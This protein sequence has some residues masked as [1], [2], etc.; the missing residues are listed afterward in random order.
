MQEGQEPLPH[1]AMRVWLAVWEINR[2]QFKC[3]SLRQLSYNRE[4]DE[5][6]QVGW[7]LSH[8]REWRLK[9]WDVLYWDH[10]HGGLY[11][12]RK[13]NTVF[14]SAQYANCAQLNQFTVFE[15]KVTF[16]VW[17]CFEIGS[18]IQ[19][20][21]ASNSLCSSRLSWSLDPLASSF[22]VLV[23]VASRSELCIRSKFSGPIEEESIFTR[24]QVK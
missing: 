24:H 8:G 15:I 10:S 3:D 20:R 1:L 2:K 21:P 4:R 22:Q 7:T 23:C 12:W 14:N 17:F 9:L 16:W 19:F 5:G 6:G 13:G 18:L 11:S